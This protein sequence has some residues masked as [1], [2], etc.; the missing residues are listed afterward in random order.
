VQ[1][2]PVLHSLSLADI[3]DLTGRAYAASREAITEVNVGLATLRQR[4]IAL[5]IILIFV[6]GVVGALYL[7]YRRLVAEH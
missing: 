4:R 5:V 6:L 1:V 7:K 3:E 2:Q